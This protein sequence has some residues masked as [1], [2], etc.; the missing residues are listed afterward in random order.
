[1]VIEEGFDV[2]NFDENSHQEQMEDILN[3]EINYLEA[4]LRKKSYEMKQN[5]INIEKL[6]AESRELRSKIEKKK[7]AKSIMLDE[8]MPKKLRPPIKPPIKKA[9]SLKNKDMNLDLDV[10]EPILSELESDESGEKEVDHG[11]YSS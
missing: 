7:V 5:E 11:N 2:E 9:Q 4:L 1:M 8:K 10:K 6:K 3:K